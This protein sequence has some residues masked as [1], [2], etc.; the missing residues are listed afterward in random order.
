M[1]TDYD[2]GNQWAEKPLSVRLQQIKNQWIN[3]G[4]RQRGMLDNLILSAEYLEEKLAKAEE[5][6]KGKS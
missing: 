4:E 3:L 2:P 1:A 6:L 5:A